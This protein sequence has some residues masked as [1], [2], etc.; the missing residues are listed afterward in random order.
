MHL[1]IHEKVVRTGGT[2]V[3]KE[4]TCPVVDPTN[5]E[6]CR[7]IN[8]GASLGFLLEVGDALDPVQSVC[9]RNLRKL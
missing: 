1:Y 6:C 7:K 5:P 8:T 4:K 3:N 2:T 9:E